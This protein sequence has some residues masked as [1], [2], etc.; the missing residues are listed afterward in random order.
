MK[1][2]MVCL[3]NICRSP[4]AEGILRHKLKL[5]RISAEVDSAGFEPFHE[6]DPPDRRAIATLRNKAIE[7]SNLRARLF[8][9]TDFD[10]FDKIFVMDRINHADVMSMAR[11]END[12][13]KVDFILN[14]SFP[15]ENREVP[16]PYYG[17][18]N[19]FESV[20]EL[21]DKACDIIVQEVKNDLDKNK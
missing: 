5:N 14:K 16:D 3:G 17:H 12:K 4:M 9:H 8:Q 6:G 7:I 20:F 19:G 13:G 18:N 10:K 11:N 15:G 1:I 2:L 21:L